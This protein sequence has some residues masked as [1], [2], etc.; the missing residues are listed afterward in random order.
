MAARIKVLLLH[1]IMAPY[2]FPLFRALSNQPGIDLTVW[3]MS[4]SARNRRWTQFND[5]LGFK[6][7]ILPAVELNYR[8]QDL[9]TYIINYSFPW[10]YL[11]RDFDAVI[12]AG[13]LDFA[14][15]ASFVLSKILRRRFV[16]WS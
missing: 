14:C 6:Y 12:S 15:Q 7:E 1:N 9:F 3:F 10:R 16:L 4:R 11:S 8:S 13:W 2:R 5:E